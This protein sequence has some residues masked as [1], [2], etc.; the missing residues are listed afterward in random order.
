MIGN[1][2]KGEHSEDVV[3]SLLMLGYSLKE[4]LH[5]DEYKFFPLRA[6]VSEVRLLAVLKIEFYKE[7]HTVGQRSVST[8][9]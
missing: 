4:N 9:R 5:Q 1:P 8:S 6:A 3:V 2:S 7:S